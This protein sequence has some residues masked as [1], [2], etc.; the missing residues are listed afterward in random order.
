M[1]YRSFF[2]IYLLIGIASLFPS[3][4]LAQTISNDV[5]DVRAESTTTTQL[6]TLDSLRMQAKSSE[7]DIQMD[8]LMQLT[9]IHTSLSADSALHYYDQ[10]RGLIQE[11]PD[12]HWQEAFYNVTFNLATIKPLERALRFS[13]LN[14]V[15]T[16]AEDTKNYYFLMHVYRQLSQLFFHASEL[17]KSLDYQLKAMEVTRMPGM[18]A[19]TSAFP[20][21]SLAHIYGGREEGRL[22]ADTAS[23]MIEAGHSFPSRAL[24]WLYT[25]MGT[26]YQKV[27]MEDV[28]LTNYQK[29]YSFVESGEVIEPDPY[30]LVALGKI[31]LDKNEFGKAESYYQQAEGLGQQNPRL[32]PDPEMEIAHAMIQLSF[33]TNRSDLAERY[34]MKIVDSSPSVGYLK[35]IA[36][37]YRTLYKLNMANADYANATKHLTS[38]FIYSDS[39]DVI[40]KNIDAY[41]HTKAL[42]LARKRHQ[43]EVVEANLKAQKSKSLVATV[44]L[45]FTSVL[46]V[47]LYMSRIKYKNLNAALFVK[48]EEV[49]KSNEALRVTNEQLTEAKMR[50]EESDR[51]KT[52]I[53]QNMSHEIRTPL[54]SILGY[55]EMIEDERENKLEIAS[56]IQ[57]GGRRLMDTLTSVMDLA[58]LEGG[59]TR[60]NMR[61]FE[62]SEVIQKNLCALTALAQQ[63]GLNI[64]VDYI[65]ADKL[66]VE[67]DKAAFERVL[68]NLIHNAIHFTESGSVSLQVQRVGQN[69]VVKIEDTGIGMTPKFLPHAFDPF[70]QESTGLGRSHEG[71]GLGLTIAKRL[72]ELMEGRINV[73][74]RKGQGSTFTLTLPIA[75]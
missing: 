37:A 14:Q 30:L 71:M 46:L 23:A 54:T 1:I 5:A 2:F 68:N 64:N 42:E 20:Y 61:V 18:P 75:V 49:K 50:A 45:L 13:F 72:V 16:Y 26:Y 25:H 19:Y 66:E 58:H 44:I 33:E 29:A 34:A 9:Q 22:Y 11:A 36:Q 43:I 59:G 40:D 35:Y 60:L 38:Y 24:H 73:V 3:Q 69:A 56:Q 41:F 31:Y 39:L 4:V 10:L 27:G 8:A 67:A 32:Y 74:S 6:A 55:A 28:A 62:I 65:D 47:F 7:F 53:L 63:K 12:T 57:R 51:L 21:I 17:D 52:S 70:R 48:N 15:A